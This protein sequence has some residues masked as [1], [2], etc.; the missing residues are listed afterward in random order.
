MR[1]FLARAVISTDFYGKYN[2]F[3]LFLGFIAPGTHNEQGLEDT[4]PTQQ[5]LIGNRQLMTDM[6][7]SV[8]KIINVEPR[9]KNNRK[10]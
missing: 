10:K 1:P 3:F 4:S 2:V 5:K 9:A 7:K 8:C 6:S